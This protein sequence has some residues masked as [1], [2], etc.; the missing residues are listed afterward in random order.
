LWRLVDSQKGHEKGAIMTTIQKLFAEHV[1][2]KPAE[3]LRTLIHVV[4]LTADTDGTEAS[5]QL[6]PLARLA[7]AM[8]RH[9]HGPDSVETLT[10]VGLLCQLTGD[11]RHLN[12]GLR[13]ARLHPEHIDAVNGIGRYAAEVGL[14]H[15]ETD[16]THAV[17]LWQEGLRWMKETECA[18]GAWVFWESVEKRLPAVARAAGVKHGPLLSAIHECLARE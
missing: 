17:K 8:A 7:E 4:T 12:E 11:K 16:P 10:A 5:E 13:I 9:I 1:G 18:G 2:D 3:F 14:M 6:L 15:A